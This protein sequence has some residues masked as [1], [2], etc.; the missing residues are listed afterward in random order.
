MH[1]LPSTECLFTFAFFPCVQDQAAFS[2]LIPTVE[3]KLV[4]LLSFVD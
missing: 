2:Y 3:S 4:S 1:L